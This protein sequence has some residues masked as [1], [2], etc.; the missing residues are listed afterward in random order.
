MVADAAGLDDGRVHA[1]VDIRLVRPFLRTFRWLEWVDDRDPVALEAL[2]HVPTPQKDPEFQW[3]RAQ[4]Q[5]YMSDAL[6]KLKG[7]NVVALQI[8]NTS[9]GYV[10]CIWLKFCLTTVSQR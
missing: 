9:K 2:V 10:N 1:P 8:I 7:L 4:L 3:L 5:C 6:E